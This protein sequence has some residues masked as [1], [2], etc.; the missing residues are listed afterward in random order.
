M[1]MLAVVGLVGRFRVRLM[2]TST[3]SQ[4]PALLD[5]FRDLVRTVR[6]GESATP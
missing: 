5:D 4:H 3:A 2:L 1:A 6:P